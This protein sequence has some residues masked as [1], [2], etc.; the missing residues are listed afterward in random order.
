MQDGNNNGRIIVIFIFFYAWQKVQTSK[1]LHPHL[2]ENYFFVPTL[3]LMHSFSMLWFSETSFVLLF[4]LARIAFS[5]EEELNRWMHTVLL[6]LYTMHAKREPVSQVYT[7]PPQKKKMWAVN[8]DNE[9]LNS[10]L[11]QDVYIVS[12]SNWCGFK[13]NLNLGN[14]TSTHNNLI[15]QNMIL[16]WPLGGANPTQSSQMFSPLHKSP[17]LQGLLVCF[18]QAS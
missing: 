11:M 15:Y 7:P 9:T 3:C 13:L 18:Y 8:R 10:M 2:S 14:F 12:N 4:H 6:S 17:S 5:T 1:F 16:N